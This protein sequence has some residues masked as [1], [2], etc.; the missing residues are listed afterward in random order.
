M[1]PTMDV[2]LTADLSCPNC[3]AQ[4]PTS[5]RQS[6]TTERHA[7]KQPIPPQLLHVCPG[8]GALVVLAPHPA[9]PERT[10]R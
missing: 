1:T 8:C 4:H 6:V 3:H 7:A 2:H 9:P 5:L 10:A